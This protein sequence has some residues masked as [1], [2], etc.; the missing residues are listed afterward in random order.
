MSVFFRLTMGFW[1]GEQLAE[2]VRMHDGFRNPPFP[3]YPNMNADTSMMVF[4][5]YTGK[6]MYFRCCCCCYFCC[7]C[8]RLDIEMR[9]KHIRANKSENEM[10]QGEIETERINEHSIVNNR[11]F[12]F[13]YI[14]KN[15]SS[16]LHFI[17][18][19]H[20]RKP[21]GITWKFHFL[22][23]TALEHSILI[24]NAACKCV[25]NSLSSTI[26]YYTHFYR[27]RQ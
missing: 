19:L 9:V 14:Y 12:C 3:S 8:N 13:I 17:Q 4:V 15:V 23:L 18:F 16:S 2:F 24:R 1:E 22:F 11:G 26:K 25:V 20:F 10:Q 5:I 21:K 6:Q 27:Q 7:C